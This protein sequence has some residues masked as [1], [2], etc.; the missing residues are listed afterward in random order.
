MTD[1]F[2]ARV[3]KVQWL[4]PRL[5]RVSFGGEDLRNF[6]STGSPDESISVILPRPGD[7]K[8]P[9]P[10]VT[11]KGWDYPDGEAPSRTYT[12]RRHDPLTSQV[13][14]EFALH[15]RG[16]AADWARHVRP[17]AVVGLSAPHA[18]YRPDPDDHRVQLFGDLPALPAV[19]RILQTLGPDCSAE[20]WLEVP[21]PADMIELPTDPRI[22]VNWHVA[23][24]GTP[25]PSRVL[26]LVVAEADPAP[27]TH[28]WVAAEATPARLARRHLRHE[29]HAP[30][31][32]YTTCGYW[33]MDQED[34]TDRYEKTDLDLVRLFTRL[35][36]D[37]KTDDEIADAVDAALAAEGL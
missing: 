4:G 23:G 10:V 11:D 8:P 2:H 30:S 32:R 16:I 15:T 20:V 12:V 26:D 7:T 19:G 17:G 37:G 6:S 35:R 29:L 22:S 24:Y 36:E 31:S 5:V 25:R 13:V 18:R 9:L 33:R 27:G 21:T 1:F 3:I 28:V 34:W 14:V